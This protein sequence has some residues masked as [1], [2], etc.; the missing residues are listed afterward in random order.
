LKGLLRFRRQKARLA[1]AAAVI[2]D[3]ETS[4]KDIVRFLGLPA[5]KVFP[6]HLAPAGRPETNLTESKKREVKTKYNLPDRFVLYVGDINYNK[7]IPTLINACK[8]ADLP[9]VICGKQ[10]QE[11][12]ERGVDIRYLA[13][14]RDWVRFV[15]GRPHPELAHYKTLLKE[16]KKNKDVHRLG[17]VSDEDIVAIFA[18]ASVY[19]QPSFYEGF[20]LPVLEAMAYG[21]PVVA[22]KTQALV[23]IAEGAALFADPKDP[24]GMANKLKEV[25]SK[26]QIAR[27]LVEKGTKHLKNFSWDKTARKTLAVYKFAA[28]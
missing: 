1:K 19:C 6:I 26:P 2:T 23:E 12:E 20:G 5:E 8:I 25:V 3:S 15:L 4:K 21:T 24:S 22:A 16:F 13:G 17:F 9:L 7:N 18:L 28:G 10:A 11:L 27:Q 14:P